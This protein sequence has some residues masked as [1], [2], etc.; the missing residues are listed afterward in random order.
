MKPNAILTALLFA[1]SAFAQ[2]TPVICPMPSPLPVVPQ[3][4][5]SATYP[6]P[7]LEWVQRVAE[8][9]RRAHQVADSVQLIFDGDSITDGWQGG[10][11]AVWAERYGK[12]NPFDFGISGDRTQHV[13]WRLAQGQADGMHPKLIAIMIGTNNLGS[14]TV[15]EIADGVKVIVADYQKRCPEAVILLQAIFPRAEKP[16]D[17]SRAKIEAINQILSK[18]GD[19]KRVIYIDFGDKF[20]EPDGTMSREVMPDFLHPSPKGYQIWADAIQ[21]VI[22]R[23]FPAK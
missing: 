19:D 22:D 8:T 14:N 21:P 1:G 6:S 20:L 4:G 12:L 18:L 11:R 5:N 17:P 13:L 9:N 3:G 15:E 2:T 10:G 7:K 16:S 23:Y